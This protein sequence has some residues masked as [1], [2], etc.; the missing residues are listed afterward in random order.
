MTGGYEVCKLSQG[1]ER[2][3]E[4]EMVVQGKAKVS[5]VSSD[6]A[7]TDGLI[8]VSPPGG[9]FIFGLSSHTFSLSVFLDDYLSLSPLGSMTN[10]A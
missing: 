10:S 8:P 4:G 3:E 7:S 2:V 5:S 9:G 6:D 1:R